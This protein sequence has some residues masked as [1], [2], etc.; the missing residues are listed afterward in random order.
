VCNPHC[1]HGGDEKRWFSGLASKLVA[2]VCQW[3]GLKITTTV[4]WFGPQNQGQRFGDLGL[5]II[6]TVSWFVPQNQVRGDLSIC[7][8]KPM[9][10][11]RQCE[12]MRRHLAA[13]FIMKQVGLGFPSFASKLAKERWMVV[14]VAL[15]RRTRAS[16][17]K[18]N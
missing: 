9:S 15:L 5:K 4:S 13:C 18:D 2:T 10:G 12:D 8:S 11:R 17:A 3:F 7:A 14:H 6:V 16:E 1:T